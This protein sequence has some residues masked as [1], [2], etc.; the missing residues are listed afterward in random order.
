MSKLPIGQWLRRI[1]LLLAVC[2]VFQA[3][4]KA[5]QLSY[6]SAVNPG[7][8]AVVG[9]T[10]GSNGENTIAS[11]LNFTY[12]PTVG[13]PFAIKA[14][15]VDIM[16]NI[17]TNPNLYNV[18]LEGTP[19]PGTLTLN[20]ATI[21]NTLAQEVAFIANAGINADA[22]H[23][24]G[25][26]LA[27]WDLLFATGNQGNN[28]AK[29]TSGDAATVNAIRDSFIANAPSNLS[30]AA[31]WLDSGTNNVPNGQSM[32]VPNGP[33]GPQIGTPEPTSLVIMAVMGFTGLGCYSR[34]RRA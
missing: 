9:N 5:D 1:C 15:C 17:P 33:N 31:V 23:A 26:Q 32:I 6:T 4:A 24:A 19:P 3:Q 27:I 21:G 16:H 8:S 7:E 13:S 30:Q 34:R 29:S 28:F 14:F 20:G 22:A 11:P 2:I 18:T 12:Y 10:N 25:A